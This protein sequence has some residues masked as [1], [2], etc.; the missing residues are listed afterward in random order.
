LIEW[1]SRG[2]DDTF[3]PQLD[4]QEISGVQVA[5]TLLNLPTYYTINY[6]FNRINLWWLR[7]Y[8]RYI[9]QPVSTD[10]DRPSDP[11]GEEPCTYE[12][13]GTAPVSIFDNY[14]WRGP[15]LACLTLFEYCMLVR[16]KHVRDA[17]VDDV[18][19][20]P[21]HPQSE[22][23]V[24]RLARSSSQATT[25]TFNGQLTEFQASE[26]AVPGGPSQNG[27]SDE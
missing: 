21:S 14:K 22:T 5:S 9:I 4:G 23:H 6:N 8:V 20:D 17:I 3:I 11:M 10:S 13:G 2:R 25:V 27:C 7:R 16:T 24:Q 18:D 26:D 15:R 12:P 1:Q 19:F